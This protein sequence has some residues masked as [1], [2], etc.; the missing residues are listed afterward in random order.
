VSDTLYSP[1]E[2]VTVVPFVATEPA[3]VTSPVAGART[4]EEPPIA[5]SIPRC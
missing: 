3:N 4:P 5:M 2:M 1:N